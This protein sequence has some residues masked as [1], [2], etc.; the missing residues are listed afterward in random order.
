MEPERPSPSERLSRVREAF[1]ALWDRAAEGVAEAPGRVNLIGEHLDYNEGWV[2]PAAIDRSVL[3]AFAARDDATV[4]VYSIDY[5]EETSVSLSEPIERDDAHLWSNYVRG[6]LAV[7]AADGF[8]GGGLDIAVTGDVPIGAGLSS[9]AALEVATAGAVRAAWRLGL[10]NERLALVCQR[11]EH[12]F[13]GVQCGVMDQ[14]ASALG[15]AGCALLIDCR[16]LTHESIPLRLEE[17]GIELVIVDSGVARQLE[18]SAYNQRREECEEAFRLLRDAIRDRTIQSLRDVTLDDLG[19][20]SHV[21][22]RTLLRRAR[23]VV[24]EQQRV[25]DSVAALGQADHAM[26]GELMNQSHSSLRDDFEVSCPQLD[27][28]QSLAKSLRGVLGARL[29]GAGFGGCTVQLVERAALAAFEQD[30]VD[31]YRGETGL[32]A[33]L[34]VCHA[35][36]GLRVHEGAA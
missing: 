24:T 28:L 5:D 15:Q 31:R 21:L 2:L 8:S 9:S 25:V 10:D 27:R 3:V 18:A 32:A 35:A 14:L 19:K 36:D 22:S 6:V 13:A 7:L 20:Y 17:H 29:T 16:T 1:R 23:H 30:V 34:L 4:R 26:F 11:A 33:K 12:E